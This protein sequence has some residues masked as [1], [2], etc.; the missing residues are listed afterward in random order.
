MQ[1]QEQPPFVTFETRAEEDRT[2][3]IV[4]G[5]FVGRDVDYVL[6]VPMGSKDQ[7]EAKVEDWF[8]AKQAE[9]SQQPPRFSPLWLKSFRE[10][11]KAWKEGQELPLE[12]QPIKTW[13]VASPAQIKMLLGLHVLTVETLAEANEETLSR[14]GMGAR[15]LK[16]QAITWLKVRK[17][18]KVA[19]SIQGLEAQV[20]DLTAANAELQRKLE[21]AVAASG[22]AKTAQE[23]LSERVTA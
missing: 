20:R 3:S 11:Y 13:P 14:L 4:A 23:V 19:M 9:A 7:F 21:A 12:G 15:A 22:G 10:H 16:E 18:S 8:A 1:P 2:A 6:V 17:D 5:G